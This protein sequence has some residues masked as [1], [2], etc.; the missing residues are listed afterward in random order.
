MADIQDMDLGAFIKLEV[1][2]KHETPD[3]SED[4][5]MGSAVIM[6]YQV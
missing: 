5:G 1:P 3:L 6:V 4:R 2:I